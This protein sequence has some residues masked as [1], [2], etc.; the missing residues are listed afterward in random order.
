MRL[1]NP[2]WRRSG[3]LQ[4]YEVI[5]IFGVFADVDLDPVHLAAELRASFR[6]VE[7]DRG[8]GRIAESPARQRR[9]GLSKKT[10][11]RPTR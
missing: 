10:C 3:V 6:I 8:A 9:M 1:L 4:V 11:R 2:P 5:E 7:G